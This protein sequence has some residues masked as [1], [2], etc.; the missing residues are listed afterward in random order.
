MK[1]RRKRKTTS[2]G[3]PLSIPIGTSRD[4]AA[5]YTHEYRLRPPKS[6]LTKEEKEHLQERFDELMAEKRATYRKKVAQEEMTESEAT[7]A[8]MHETLTRLASEFGIGY[9]RIM[10][11]HGF[12]S[13]AF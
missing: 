11:R 7:D 3:S 8:L 10:K 9:C 13:G 12:E 2:A 1:K 6:G 4:G 5:T